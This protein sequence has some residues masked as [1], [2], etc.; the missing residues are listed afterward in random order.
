MGG[1]IIPDVISAAMEVGLFDALFEESMDF[2]DLSARLGTVETPTHYLLEGELK[3]ALEALGF[4]DITIRP[5]EL[6]IPAWL[7]TVLTGQDMCFDQGA[8]AGSNLSV[9]THW[10]QT[11]VRWILISEGKKEFE[12]R[13][14]KCRIKS[15]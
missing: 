2:H 15:G 10:T 8:I 1:D 4:G 12:R 9:H 13:K 7:S 6:T 11:G 5:A 3:Q 14:Q